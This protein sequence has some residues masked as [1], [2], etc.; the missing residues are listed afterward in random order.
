MT[1]KKQ[2]YHT[3]LDFTHAFHQNKVTLAGSYIKMHTE[4]TGIVSFLS[5][6]ILLT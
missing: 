5:L 4:H 3:L 2:Q 6:H 1:K